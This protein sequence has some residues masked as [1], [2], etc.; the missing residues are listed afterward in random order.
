MVSA[1]PAKRK[2][3]AAARRKRRGVP[4]VTMASTVCK[5][6]A[7]EAPSNTRRLAGGGRMRQKD[8]PKGPSGLP[9]CRWCQKN[10]I[11]KFRGG[12]ATHCSK[13]CTHEHLM[14]TGGVRGDY[15]RRCVYARDRGVCA[16]CKY[17]TKKL[18]WEARKLRREGRLD[19]AERL[20]DE[21]QIPKHRRR[22]PMV[23]GGKVWDAD[24]VTP[25]CM[26][27]G[28][29]DL[30]NYRTMCVRCHKSVTASLAKQRAESKKTN[31]DNVV[32][33][34]PVP[35][36]FP[37]PQCEREFKSKRGVAVHKRVHAAS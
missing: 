26:G 6:D 12:N 30:D 21:H 23:L 8:L 35:E 14:T 33:G 32:V 3:A 4:R 17:D 28:L 16:L 13:E 15:V 27:G 11:P 25:V 19:D 2:P 10:E 29:T 18:S 36:L 37:C 24:H 7:G 34:D 9:V 1:K 5:R 22:L 31:S 20:L